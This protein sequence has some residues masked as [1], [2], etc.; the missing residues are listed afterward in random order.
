MKEKLNSFINSLNIGKA[1]TFENISVFPIFGKNSEGVSFITLNEAVKKGCIEVTEISEGGSVPNLKVK[2]RSEHHILIFD[3][4]TLVGAKQNRIVNTTIIILPYKEVIIPVSCVEKG[5]WNYRTQKFSSSASHSRLYP[6]LRKE[7]CRDTFQS[8][9]ESA[10]AYSNQS[11]VWNYIDSKLAYMKVNSSSSAMED[12]FTNYEDRLSDISNKFKPLDNQIGTGILINDKLALLE[13]FSNSD[14]LKGEF[15]K[16][17]SSV[18]ID[19]LEHREK[20]SKKL[21]NPASKIQ[22]LLKKMKD[23]KLEAFDGVGGGKDLRI[24]SKDFIGSAFEYNGEIL[25][26]TVFPE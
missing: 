2:N 20:T 13:I 18:G 9:K 17:I 22:G 24:A 6:E 11:K 5:R 26:M 15:Q 19:A 8:L 14:V 3:G 7:V 23:A 25:H 16:I 1:E 4:E 21:K 12:I 10:H